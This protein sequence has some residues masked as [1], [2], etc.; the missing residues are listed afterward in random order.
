MATMYSNLLL[1]T[2]CRV[3]HTVR[4]AKQCPP[5]SNASDIIDSIRNG[6]HERF[7][8]ILAHIAWDCWLPKTTTIN[9]V[10]GVVC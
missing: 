9:H 3:L 5:C 7:T 4:L 1:L 2:T 10:S 8:A 6:N